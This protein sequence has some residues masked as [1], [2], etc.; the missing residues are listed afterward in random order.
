[1]MRPS[2]FGENLMDDFFDDYFDL[3]ALDDQAKKELYGFH[4]ANRMK[5]DV[6]EHADHYEVD[7]EL[8]GFRK[9][10]LSVELK[11]GCLVVRAAKGFTKD[12]QDKETGQYVR[13]ERYAGSMTRSFYVGEDVKQEEIHAKYESG[14]LKLRIPKAEE[15]KPEV[16]EKN[17]IAIEG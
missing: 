14:V 3:R 6:Q 2:I 13:R 1:M 9:E 11:D 10:E 8:P 5:M 7:I 16:E 12:E 17:Y 15:K 4:M